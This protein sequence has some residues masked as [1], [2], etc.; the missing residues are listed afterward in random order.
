MSVSWP[1]FLEFGKLTIQSI[2]EWQTLL[3]GGIAIG[4]A[5]VGASA[6][7][8][9]IQQAETFEIDRL[10]R[11]HAAARSTLPLVLSSIME[12]GRA[13]AY[14]LR[15]IHSRC[16]GPIIVQNVAREWTLPRLPEGDT[17]ALADLI[18]TA[19]EEVSEVVAD[20]LGRVQVQASRIRDLRNRVI[21]RDAHVPKSQLL[22]NIRTIADLYARCESLFEYAR[23]ETDEV[24]SVTARVDI[25][26]ALRH[27]EFSQE[28]IQ[29]IE[30]L[31][32]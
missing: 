10:N 18:E 9:Q 5:F 14:D 7:Y 20:L 3:A 23:R 29:E 12:Y 1:E 4:A 13:V 8:R 24:P 32:P 28:E 27:L 16:P 25:S 17:A 22:M 6:V 21:R 11:R 2:K 15:T 26:R 19:S 31:G 30:Q